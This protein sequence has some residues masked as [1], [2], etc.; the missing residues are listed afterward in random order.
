MLPAA[1]FNPDYIKWV[2]DNIKEIDYVRKASAM[3]LKWDTMTDV[4]LQESPVV[5]MVTQTTVSRYV[6]KA[7]LNFFTYI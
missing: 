3:S 2:E 1:V 7:F 4:D 5:V 6:S